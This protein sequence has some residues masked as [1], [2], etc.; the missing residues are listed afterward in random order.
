[1]VLNCCY[2]RETV[3]VPVDRLSV[4]IRKIR[5]ADKALPETHRCQTFHVQ[6]VPTLICQVWPLGAPLQ[7]THAETP[8]AVS[9]EAV[10][11]RSTNFLSRSTVPKNW[12]FVNWIMKLFFLSGRRKWGWKWNDT[13]LLGTL[14]LRTAI[15][16]IVWMICQN[17]KRGSCYF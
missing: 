7:T 9:Y 8:E 13:S 2:R 3:Q 4:A 10:R 1:M 11:R 12:F 15:F 17:L 14:H 5:R 16:F 6:R